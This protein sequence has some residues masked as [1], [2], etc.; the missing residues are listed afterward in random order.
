MIKLKNFGINGELHDVECQLVG[1][2]HPNYFIKAPMGQFKLEPSIE[3]VGLGELDKVTRPVSIETYRIT[4]EYGAD[5]KTA[6]NAFFLRGGKYPINTIGGWM[7]D[8]STLDGFVPTTIGQGGCGIYLAEVNFEVDQTDDYRRPRPVLVHRQFLRVEM[9][10]NGVEHLH[11]N[12]RPVFHFV[13]S[14]GKTK[15]VSDSE[16]IDLTH[17]QAKCVKA[18]NTATDAEGIFRWISVRVDLYGANSSSSLKDEIF[19]RYNDRSNSTENRYDKLYELCSVSEHGRGMY[20][21]KISITPDS[22]LE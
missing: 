4:G 16:E 10:P 2:G 6:E 9:N 21:Q 18:I 5:V 14:N 19:S 3:Q 8:V 20:R 22:S 1:P 15:L 7:H 17:A 11:P 12:R 13:E